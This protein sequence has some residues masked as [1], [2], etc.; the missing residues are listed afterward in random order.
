MPDPLEMQDEEKVVEEE[1]YAP[2]T[3]VVCVICGAEI[4]QGCVNTVTGNSREAHLTRQTDYCRESERR[5][6]RE[7]TNE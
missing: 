6:K 1:T 4:G 3:T 7:R 5:R 2:Y